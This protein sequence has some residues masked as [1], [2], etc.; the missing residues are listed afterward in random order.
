MGLLNINGPKNLMPWNREPNRVPPWT[1]QNVTIPSIN[2]P[3]PDQSNTAAILHEDATPAAIHN[4]QQNQAIF[5]YNRAC[6]IAVF[7]KPIN[8]NWLL[9]WGNNATSAGT[10]AAYFDVQN[11]LIGVTL[12]I[13]GATIS[14]PLPNGWYRCWMSFLCGITSAV[15]VRFYVASASGVATFNGLNQDSLYIWNPSAGEGYDPDDSDKI[16]TTET[17]I[18]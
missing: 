18:T 1:I 14:A 5:P 8:R 4:V 17:P 16:Y 13:L 9:L 15:S 7:A 2:N 11:G 12:N 10:V 6:H 3:A